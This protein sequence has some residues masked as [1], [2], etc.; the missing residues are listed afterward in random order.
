MKVFEAVPPPHE[1]HVSVAFCSSRADLKLQGTIECSCFKQALS[2]F[3]R[4]PGGTDSTGDHPGFCRQPSFSAR[5]VAEKIGTPGVNAL[6]PDGV[7]PPFSHGPGL[8]A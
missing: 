3:V 7:S 8:G 1:R 6:V 5:P 4:V 2:S